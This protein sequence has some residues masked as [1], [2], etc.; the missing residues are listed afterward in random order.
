MSNKEKPSK[1][2]QFAETLQAMEIEGKTLAE[3]MEWLK[4]EGC[5]ISQG[6]LS[7]YLSKLRESR[8]QSEVLR[9][10]A[11]GARQSKEVKAAYAKDPAPELD[12]LIKYFQ[13]IIFQL[14]TW[15]SIN[16]DALKLADQL[17]NT[18]LSF[19]S[20]RTKAAHKEREVA[21]AEQKYV[22]TKKDEG[23]KALEYC[24][25][26]AKELPEVQELFKAAFLGLQKAKRG[27]ATPPAGQ[28]V[29]GLNAAPAA[30]TAQANQATSK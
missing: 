4:L 25:S 8:R 9:Q 15:G 13:T 2:D 18:V 19:I 1:L 21:L 23:Q 14:S 11:T 6:A 28:T 17:T 24:L 16:P 10:I 29:S 22:E 5:V 7:N 12:T 30:P 27:A 26:E 3:M 20:A